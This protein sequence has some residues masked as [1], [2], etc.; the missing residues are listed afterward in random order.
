MAVPA[1]AAAGTG[2]T[3][4]T[5][6]L[7]P[8]YPA[9][10]S[11]GD[12]L[13]LHVSGQHGSSGSADVVEPSGWT[14]VVN[15]DTT[16]ATYYGAVFTKVA[17]GTESGTLSVSK[18]NES[19]V[20]QARIYRFTGAGAATDTEGV[21]SGLHGSGTTINMLSVTTT[22]ADRLCLHLTFI[23]DSTSNQGAPVQASATGETGGDWTE[24]VAEYTSTT[25]P[26]E[27]LG[28]QTAGMA[29]AGTISGG[30]FN[31]NHSVI[32]FKVAFAIFP[33]T[34]TNATVSP[35]V[36]TV[37]VAGLAPTPAI[38]VAPAAS[39][40]AVAAFAPTPQLSVPIPVGTITVDGLVPV[41]DTGG[42]NA[43]VSPEAA[44]VA[45]AGLTP[46]PAL[47][48]EPPL[49]T[50]A[51][52]GPAPTPTLAVAPDAATVAVAAFAPVPAITLL[53]AQATISAAGVTPTPTITVSPDQAT[54]STAALAPT[55]Q[56]TL[57]PD[58]AAVT[59]AG[60]APTPQITIQPGA[61]TLLVA[62]FAP[63]L[64]GS[65]AFALGT[66]VCDDLSLAAVACD[67]LSLTADSTGTLTLTAGTADS[68]SLTAAGTDSL[69]LTSA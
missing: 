68:L 42:T 29:S 64:E 50:I 1:Y 7:S 69:T 21:A 52:A 2:S 25:G 22:A 14:T 8:A 9:G 47:T 40:I 10:I 38:T 27:S 48:V 45:L 41:I 51:V 11:A 15:D 36:A 58:P 43:T 19:V 31:T 65:A 4:T 44:T 32:G 35:P 3:S 30:S 56:I 26:D 28:L 57:L 62:A 66:V 33:A 6:T 20:S 49:G 60:L 12:L 34:S 63:T 18:A 67:S 53:P 13:V 39:T 24:A 16:N 37:S 46:N 23:R 61:A 59:V 17:D 55:P 54:V 5:G